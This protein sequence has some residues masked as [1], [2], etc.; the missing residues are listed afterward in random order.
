MS[1]ATP[2]EQQAIEQVLKLIDREVWVVTSKAG[3]RRGG[4]LATWVQQASLD[5]A[6]PAMVV[7][8]APHHSTCELIAESG[9][10]VLHLI[11][12]D[13]IS[14][15]MNFAIGSGRNRD[16]LAGL[17]LRTAVTGM[18]ILRECLAWL[19]CRV[20]ERCDT[21][22][23]IYFWADAVSG[24]RTLAARDTENRPL[25]EREFFAAATAEQKQALRGNLWA[26]IETQ[27]TMVECW[28]AR[29]A[30]RVKGEQMQNAE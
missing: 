10:F 29:V 22:D 27:R 7:G 24:G 19:D 23:R 2:Q 20:I 26:D 6:R 12:A 17:E 30:E 16:K 11:A 8:L 18:P 25:G 9:A 5:P 4:L 14:L 1:S 15:A 3:S 21:G 13:Q 28:R